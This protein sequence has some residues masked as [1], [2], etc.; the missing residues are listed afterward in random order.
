MNALKVLVCVAVL[1]TI[2]LIGISE[3]VS[4]T[5][6]TVNNTYNI[7]VC[8]LSYY[9]VTVPIITISDIGLCNVTTSNFN[10]LTNIT[11]TTIVPCTSTSYNISIYN[12]TL[13]NTS[14]YKIFNWNI[15]TT[16]AEP[17]ETIISNQ[18]DIQT[19]S[20]DLVDLNKYYFVNNSNYVE[21][22]AL[23]ETTNIQ[24]LFYYNNIS[25]KNVRVYLNGTGAE[26]LG[27]ICRVFIKPDS[28][29][30]VEL[31]PDVWHDFVK[32]T[33]NTAYYLAI[34]YVNQQGKCR[35]NLE[36]V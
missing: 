28:D 18:Q 20:V 5:N 7:T 8:N 36:V 23:T 27:T 9:N 3:E 14:I 31:T 21:R 17:V 2:G 35:Y 12:I 29:E 30:P 26:G 22:D 13:C 16:L 33:N 34:K 10:D 4:L 19:F 32:P 11:T 25:G 1:S 15:S 6:S 24:P